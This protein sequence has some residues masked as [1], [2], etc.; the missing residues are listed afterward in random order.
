MPASPIAQEGLTTAFFGVMVVIDLVLV[1]VKGASP[2]VVSVLAAIAGSFLVCAMAAA[3]VA[4]VGVPTWH[5]WTSVP[6]FVVG[7]IAAGLPLIAVF[8]RNLAENGAYVAA[9]AVVETLAALAYLASG[10]VNMA[11]G[12]S[13]APFACAALL[14]VVAAV[15]PF[16]DSVRK[17]S[18][19]PVVV[20]ALAFVALVVARY[21][22][23]AVV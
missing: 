7:A 9:I 21:A 22:Y 5:N 6:L 17:A 20:F 14:A 11:A 3:Y 12:F 8:D 2:K 15:L 16:I 23:Y 19:G 13:L 18:W 1:K 10:Y 4:F